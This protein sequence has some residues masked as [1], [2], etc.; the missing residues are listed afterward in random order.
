MLLVNN[1]TVVTQSDIQLRIDKMIKVG[2]INKTESKH[3]IPKSDMTFY[4]QVNQEI[5]SPVLRRKH[6][7]SLVKNRKFFSDSLAVT[8]RKNMKKQR[9][10]RDI[11]NEHIEKEYV[12]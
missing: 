3:D 9:D 4:A 8:R 10:Q 6:N 7:P 5:F 2:S 11:A 1:S 12:R